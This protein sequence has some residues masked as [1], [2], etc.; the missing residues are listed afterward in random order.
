MKA[1]PLR[2]MTMILFLKD[3]Y[4]YPT[5][6]PDWETTNES[7]LNLA[8]IY[9]SM[10]IKNFFFHL[11]LVDQSLKGVDPFD[12]YLTDEMMSRVAAEAKVNPW[13]FFREILRIKPQ[14]SANPIKFRASRGNIG[15]Y[16]AFFCHI[17]LILIQ[18][19]QTGKSVGT[20]ALSIYLLFV[21]TENTRIN[22]L[23]KDESLR[24]Q[25][26]ERLK[27]MRD[28]LPAYM[29]HHNPREDYDNTFMISCKLW[30][31]EYS[32]AVP[33]NNEDAANNIGRG[34]TAPIAFIDEP[35]FIPF[36]D[37]IIPSMLA[38]GTAAVEEAKQH[39]THYGNIF[40]TTA[41]KKDTRSGK[42][43][44]DM[45][46]SAMVFDERKLFDCEDM[47]EAQELVRRNTTDGGCIM[48]MTLSHRQLGYTDA[49]LREAIIRAK[50]T[51]EAAERDFLNRWTSG[52]LSSPLSTELNNLLRQSERE[53]DYIEKCKR[54][55]AVSWY[56]PQERI[57]EY[58]ANNDCTAG[59][60]TS[61]GMGRDSMALVVVDNRTLRTVATLNVNETNVINF[62][63]FIAE[64]L[65]KYPK[66]TLIPERKSTGIT[67]I[68]ML[69][70][71]LPML[72]EDPFKRI[73]NT[74]VDDG[75]HLEGE[76]WKCL[77]NHIDTRPR[78][79]ADKYKRRFGF[80]TTGDG[81]FSRN[82]LYESTLVRAAKLTNIHMFDKSL[83][84]EITGLVVKNSRIDHKTSGHDDMV[85]GWMLAAWMLLNG[86]HL[87]MYG[88]SAPLRDAVEYTEG[89]DTIPEQTG[90]DK[91]INAQQSIYRDQIIALGDELAACQDE[92]MQ[93]RLEQRLQAL[94]NK[95]KVDDSTIPTFDALINSAN[96]R[97]RNKQQ[98]R[99]ASY[100]AGNYNSVNY[101]NSLYS[102]TPKF[103]A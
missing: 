56:V 48:N 70:I 94:Y 54:N 80:A 11:A 86:R 13:Y 39:N 34:S 17:D 65:V 15:M 57:L 24:R 25:Q 32:T 53:P 71:E 49:W 82:G 28:Y 60:D 73:F 58:M 90:Y 16:W 66:V 41:G 78:G 103:A 77:Y 30:N 47:F 38:A 9:K 51:G 89:Q 85:I 4:K 63:K 72:G 6:R 19:R 33:R 10:G 64:F 99:H 21:A 93:Y 29:N 87:A 2:G 26:V 74:A 44:Y 40:T 61:E 14:A 42:F 67:I 45:L 97:R 35:P 79:H 27:A 101:S 100:A 59:L 5:A 20:D 31:N 69:L 102:L 84:D 75:L 8:K 36:I 81:R 55:Y 52:G 37:V 3:W 1:H 22:M 12:P 18:P 43:I 23:T 7:F 88:I 83:I 62:A 96:E 98:A 91:Y 92:F 76:E 68:D 95:V 50:A 46:Q